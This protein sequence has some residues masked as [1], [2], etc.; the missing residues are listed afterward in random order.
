MRMTPQL[1]HL[2]LRAFS[3]NELKFLLLLLNSPKGAYGRISLSLGET[4]RRLDLERPTVLVT[5]SKLATKGIIRAKVATD[6][7]RAVP[8]TTYQVDEKKLL[9]YCSLFE[10]RCYH[11]GTT[12]ATS[13]VKHHARPKSRGGKKTIYRNTAKLATNCFVNLCSKF[14]G[15]AIYLCANCHQNHHYKP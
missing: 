9:A 4:E 13:Y 12:T 3:G 14:C 6:P 11:C 5:Q 1:M 7:V 10:V 8:I 2:M 15:T